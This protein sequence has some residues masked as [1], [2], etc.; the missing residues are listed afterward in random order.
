ML[1]CG[2]EGGIDYDHLASPQAQNLPDDGADVVDIHLLYDP[3]RLDLSLK[4]ITQS[5][6]FIGGFGDKQGQLRQKCQLVFWTHLLTPMNLREG[7]GVRVGEGERAPARTNHSRVSTDL[8][9]EPL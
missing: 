4:S 3:A 2:A 9:S 6:K 5:T 1:Q 7:R 8:R